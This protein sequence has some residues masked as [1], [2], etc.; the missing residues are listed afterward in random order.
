MPHARGTAARVVSWGFLPWTNMPVGAIAPGLGL[1]VSCPVQPQ[2]GGLGALGSR[3]ASE[4][5]CDPA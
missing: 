4:L 1:L 5:G 3:P 2:P